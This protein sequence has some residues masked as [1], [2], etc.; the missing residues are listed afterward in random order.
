MAT[1]ILFI[2]SFERLWNDETFRIIVGLAT[3]LL[4]AGTVIY[5][6]IEGWS[7]L[8]ALYFSVV[9]LATVGYGDLAPKTDIGRAFTIV[10]ILAGIGLIVALA[11]RV[12]DS[13]VTD[14]AQRLHQA[15]GRAGPSDDDAGGPDPTPPREHFR[16]P[17]DG[18]TTDGG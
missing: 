4:V 1:I 8:E 12:V 15:G 13:M 16:A 9:S 10:F 5:M 14:R 6:V 18:E 11:S 2:R 17:S 3:G 7:P